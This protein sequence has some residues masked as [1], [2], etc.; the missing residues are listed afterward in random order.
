MNDEM[1]VP[2]MNRRLQKRVRSD[3]WTPRK[4][5]IFLEHLAATSNVTASAAEAGMSGSGVYQLRLRDSLFREAW[6]AAL[7]EGY[8]RLEMMLLERCFATRPT[9]RIDGGKIV[10]TAETMDPELALR[11]LKQHWAKKEGKRRGGIMPGKASMDEVREALLKKLS[12]LN[13]RMGGKG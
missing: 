8:A 4:R 12:A 11:L 13:K 2:G 3:G 6:S 5:K 7:E 10:A 9:P 1:I